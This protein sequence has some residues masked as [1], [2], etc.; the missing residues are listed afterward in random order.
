VLRNVNGTEAAR[1]A[2]GPKVE[3][4]AGLKAMWQGYAFSE[5]FREERGHYYMLEDQNGHIE[6]QL[7]AQLPFAKERGLARGASA[8]RRSAT[9]PI[10]CIAPP[11]AR[12]CS[13]RRESLL[14]DQ[15]PPQQ[16]SGSRLRDRV[17]DD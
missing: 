7:T 12:C 6:L 16:L 4:D 5:D 3:E 13:G 11:L 15:N 2:D 8:R 17:D 10:R 14:P 9:Y 1:P